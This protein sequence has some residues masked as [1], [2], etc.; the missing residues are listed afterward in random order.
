MKDFFEWL[1]SFCISFLEAGIWVLLALFLVC[2][3]VLT[4]N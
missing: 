2:M 1:A 4:F 3:L